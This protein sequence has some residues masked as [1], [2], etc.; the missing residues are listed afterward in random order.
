MISTRYFLFVALLFLTIRASATSIQWLVKPEYDHVEFFSESVFKCVKNGKMQ[1]VDKEGRFLLPNPVDYVTDYSEG[2]ALVC[3]KSGSNTK[4]C[5]IFEENGL[6]YHPVQGN[7]FCTYY[8]PCSEGMVAVKDMRGKEGYLFAT[9]ELAISCQYELATPFKQGL[10]VVEGGE[11]GNNNKRG[12]FHY[13][14]YLGEKVDVTPSL[15]FKSFE[16]ALNFN[17]R[18]EAMIAHYEHVYIINLEGTILRDFDGLNY[19]IPQREIDFVYDEE[20]NADVQHYSKFEPDPRYSIYKKD[21]KSGIKRNGFPVV[22]A[23]FDEIH[24]ISSEFAIVK[25]NRHEGV[26]KFIGGDYGVSLSTTELVVVNG[27]ETPNVVFTLGTPNDGVANRKISFDR[28]DGKYEPITLVNNQYTFQPYFAKSKTDSK[29]R[30]KVFGDDLL[31]CEHEIDIQKVEIKIAISKLYCHE[32]YADENDLQRVKAIVE[33]KSVMAVNVKPVFHI[34]ISE[35]SQNSIVSKSHSEITLEPN[36]QKE[37]TV[38]FKV[39]NK[40][41]VKVTLNINYNNK[42]VGSKTVEVE[43]TPFY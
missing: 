23:Q 9:G 39:V 15:P 17:E 7:Y 12:A 24:E 13:I 35:D 37:M 11:K 25:N 40:E 43:L 41:R 6:I 2:F 27:E 29:I 3:M 8:S 31:L 28:G 36:E 1:L 42:V 14:D 34:P 20:D 18:G 26:L 5:G 10:A 30:M 32:D 21:G 33:N 19:T 22:L 38:V 4:I 16:T